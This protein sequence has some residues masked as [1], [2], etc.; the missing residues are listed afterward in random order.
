MLVTIPWRTLAKRTVVEAVTKRRF[1]VV[2][3][4][5]FEEE[6]KAKEDSRVVVHKFTTIN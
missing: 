5:F 1:V 3:G 4:I 2:A 6:E